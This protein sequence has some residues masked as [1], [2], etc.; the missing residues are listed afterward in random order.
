[1][2]L[3]KGSVANVQ[4]V[5]TK[6]AIFDLFTNQVFAITQSQPFSIFVGIFGELFKNIFLF[7]PATHG[8][9]IDLSYISNGIHILNSS[10]NL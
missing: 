9:W 2:T 7:E 1:M 8:K 3:W 10:K 5:M 6:L 4:V